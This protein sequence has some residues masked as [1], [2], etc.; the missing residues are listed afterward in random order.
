MADDADANEGGLTPTRVQRILIVDDE[1]DI[2]SSLKTL[3]EVS[4]SNTEVETAANGH[5]GLERLKETSFDLILTDYKMP[6]MNGLDFLTQAREHAP[7]TPAIL[8]TAFPDLNIAVKAINETG[9]EN[10][11]TKPLQPEQ[12]V[13]TVREVL[14]ERRAAEQRDKSFARSM[15]LLRRKAEKEDA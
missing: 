15:E 6:G 13:E 5:K 8:I 2:L 11:I 14:R 7:D 3:F 1:D 10:F 4:L 9:V 12:V